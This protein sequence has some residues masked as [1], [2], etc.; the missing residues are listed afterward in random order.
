MAISKICHNG[1]CPSGKRVITQAQRAG[2]LA[3]LS[4]GRREVGAVVPGEPSGRGRGHLLGMALQ[5][6][7]SQ[8]N[9]L[10]HVDFLEL[11]LQDELAVRRQSQIEC[12]INTAAFREL[13]SLE[14]FDGEFNRSI[15]RKQIF[16]LAS[17]SFV[18]QHKAVLLGPPGVSKSYLA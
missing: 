8:S 12:R 17:G 14:G 13:K 11:V 15:N 4:L 2:V 3:V 18:R 5:D 6:G 10:A 9:R 7:E 16:D 1:G